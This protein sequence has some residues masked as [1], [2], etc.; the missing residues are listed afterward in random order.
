MDLKPRYLNHKYLKGH[1]SISSFRSNA[2]S[3][4][5]PPEIEK[6]RPREGENVAGK[7]GYGRRTE[8]LV[9]KVYNEKKALTVYRLLP[10]R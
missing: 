9:F 1:F 2:F 6:W 10:S 7:Y 5:N 8:V 4:E 3:I